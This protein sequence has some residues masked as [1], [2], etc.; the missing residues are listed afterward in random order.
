MCT[1]LHRVTFEKTIGAQEKT[2]CDD[3]IQ[4]NVRMVVNTETKLV[5][6]YARPILSK[7]LRPLTFSYSA[8]FLSRNGNPTQKTFS[9]I[10]HALDANETGM[11]YGRANVCHFEDLPLQYNREHTVIRFHF[12]SL[13]WNSNMYLGTLHHFLNAQS[14]DETLLSSLKACQNQLKEETR[15]TTRAFHHAKDWEN[16]YNLLLEK[17]KAGKKNLKRRRTDSVDPDDCAGTH[18]DDSSAA[19][20]VLDGIA[21]VVQK[22]SLPEIE[23]AIDRVTADLKKLEDK[24]KELKR[25][26][27][28]LDSVKSA[29]CL[30]CKHMAACDA[31]M[32]TVETTSKKCPVCRAAIETVVYPFV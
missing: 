20:H 14:L 23:V 30:P 1:H 25:C 18:I 5:G 26:V 9:L 29:I 4:W 3:L 24:K 22:G 11:L 32:H 17:P 19:S 13:K 15:K 2:V 7:F 21:M 28:C 10:D 6:V 8:T 16:K 31:C 27:I 12:S